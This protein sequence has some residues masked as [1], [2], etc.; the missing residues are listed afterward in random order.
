MS[1][2]VVQEQSRA[3]VGMKADSGFDDIISKIAEVDLFDGH[4]A[5]HGTDPDKN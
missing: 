1:Q 2:T 3:F 5:I 4:C